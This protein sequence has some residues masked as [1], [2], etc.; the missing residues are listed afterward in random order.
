MLDH[1]SLLILTDLPGFFLL[2]S[3]APALSA[4]SIQVVRNNKGD[5]KVRLC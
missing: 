1:V 4:G 2:L 5:L 3:F